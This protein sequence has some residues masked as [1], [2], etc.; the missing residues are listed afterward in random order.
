MMDTPVK[1]GESSNSSPQVMD[2]DYEITFNIETLRMISYCTLIFMVLV[3]IIVTDTLVAIPPEQTVIFEIF[4][5]NH[6]CNVF[7]HQP[8]RSISALLVLFYIVPMSTFVNLSLFRAKTAFKLNQIPKWVLTLHQV[9]FPVIFIS[10]CYVYMWFVESPDEAGFVPHYIPYV[11]LQLAM[12]LLSIQEVAFLAET[13]ALPFNNSQLIARAYLV[14]LVTT[15][16][17]CQLCTFTVIG[18]HP[19]LDSKNNDAQRKGFQFLMYFYSFLAIIV[20]IPLSYSHRK[21]AA[22]MTISF[23]SGPTRRELGLSK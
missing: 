8:S 13:G 20:P 6:I 19:I 12:G 21:L 10:V 2:T 18:G 22:N 16:V 17:A 15:T 1:V 7:D 14:F 4:G 11:M 9:F 5:F 3:G 23:R